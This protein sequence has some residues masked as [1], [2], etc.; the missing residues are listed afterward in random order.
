MVFLQD[1]FGKVLGQTR[2]VVLPH[3][4]QILAVVHTGGLIPGDESFDEP[5]RERQT[6]V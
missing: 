1:S 2:E 6:E 3:I 4:G 5:A